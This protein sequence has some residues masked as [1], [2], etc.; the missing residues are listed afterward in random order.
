M[1]CKSGKH[2]WDDPEDQKRCCNGYTRV[3]A[4]RRQE[5]EEIGAEHIVLRE[6]FRGWLKSDKTS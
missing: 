4:L 5:L 3:Q 2:H 6:L 1:K